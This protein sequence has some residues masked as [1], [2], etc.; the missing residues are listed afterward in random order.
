MAP[1]ANSGPHPR[2][3]D[4]ADEARFAELSRQLVEAV[5]AVLPEWIEGLVEVRVREWSGHV[6]AEVAAAALT[7][8]AA[9]RDAVVPELRALLTTDIDAQ[10]ANPLAVLRGATRFAHAVL[11]DLGVPAMP[12]DAFAEQSFPDDRYGLVPATWS[13]VDPSLHEIGITWGAAKAYVHKARRRAEG[14][15]VIVTAI[16]RELMD[17]SKITAAFADVRIVRSGDDL[18][19]PDVVLVDLAVPGAL[20]AALETGATV[21]AYGS[22]V[23]EERLAAARGLGATAMPR[24]LFFRRLRDGSLLS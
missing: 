8:G 17:R 19:R 22:H 6:S 13:D 9:A 1:D 5:D 15:I 18:G 7:A 23:D 24:S 20:E 21:I 12:R 16:T 3:A 10:R 2:R 14:S 11:A 4:D